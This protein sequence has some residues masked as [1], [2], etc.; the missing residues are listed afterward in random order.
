MNL[1]LDK[2]KYFATSSDSCSSTG[3]SID[4]EASSTTDSSTTNL[5]PSIPGRE[6]HPQRIILRKNLD[7]FELSSIHQ[8]ILLLP[9]I[10]AACLTRDRTKGKNAVFLREKLHK[11]SRGKLV[12]GNKRS[13]KWRNFKKIVGKRRRTTSS[14]A[15]VARP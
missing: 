8:L 15:R 11:L 4:F 2:S 13:E 10:L 9:L 14:R 7:I 6:K 1:M 12:E 5:R 3:N